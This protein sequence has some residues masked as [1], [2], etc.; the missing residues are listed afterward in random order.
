MTPEWPLAGE[1]LPGTGAGSTGSSFSSRECKIS[2][3]FSFPS[4]KIWLITTK[5]LCDRLLSRQAQHPAHPLDVRFSSA[6]FSDTLF[7]RDVPKPI[8]LCV[9]PSLCRPSGTRATGFV[10]RQTA[11]RFGCKFRQFELYR[12]LRYLPIWRN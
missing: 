5:S 3:S 2:L 8:F 7:L 6:P 4:S 9:S 1:G 11:R 12:R 10:S